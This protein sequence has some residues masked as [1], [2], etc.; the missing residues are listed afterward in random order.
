MHIAWS[1]YSFKLFFYE[2]KL[3]NKDPN[4]KELVIVWLPCIPLSWTIKLLVIG[5]SIVIGIVTGDVVVSC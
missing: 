5:L 2:C 1:M 4:P 3:V